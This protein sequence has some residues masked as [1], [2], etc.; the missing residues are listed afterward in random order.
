M[1]K[2]PFYDPSKSY[3]ENY[4]QG[5]F[6]AFVAPKEVKRV[7]K[8]SAK[9]LGQTVYTPFGIPAGPLLNSNFTT[10]AFKKG[11]DIC[12]YKTVR[13]H[14]HACHPWPNVL[15]A[16]F[17]GDLTLEKA[18]HEVFANTEYTEP[19]SIT[20]SFG[21]P[22]KTPA[23]WQADIRKALQE[24]GEGQLLIGSFQGTGDGSG[25][26]D[27]Y[28]ADFVLTAKLLKETGVKVME[29]NLSCPNEGKADLLCFDIQRTK[30]IAQKVKD[31]IGDIPLILKIAFMDDQ[32]LKQFVGEL[33][34]V[35][36]AFSAINT[37]A[38]TI[39]DKDGNQAL[40]GAGRARSGVCGAGIKWAG[41]DMVTRLARLRTEL[42]MKYEII[43]VGGV[44]SAADFAEYRQVGADA[45]MSATGA[46]WNPELGE[47]IYQANL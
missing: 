8:P 17:D 7:K 19:L 30:V 28:V 41:L 24:A 20:N 21:V 9:F 16:H 27:K 36:Q 3:E 12:V 11:F 25:D 32:R 5:P 46:M 14:E 45:V 13:S 29:A 34:N 31:E 40:P 38:A 44:L 39:V 43:G 26:F 23:I 2:T 42:N 37:I 1:L 22:S 18:S 6:G 10:A 15:A 4:D 47:E 35:V 33:G